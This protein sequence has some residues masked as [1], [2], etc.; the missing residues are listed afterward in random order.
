MFSLRLLILAVVV[1]AA[2]GLACILLGSVLGSLN[3]PIADT[4]GKFLTA[5]GWAL[6]V[7]AGLWYYFT[8]GTWTGRPA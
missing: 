1:A 7:L 3:I 4:I 8:G 5:Y 6:G 2:T